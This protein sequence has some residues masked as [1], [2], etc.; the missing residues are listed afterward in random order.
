MIF[1]Y[2]LIDSNR[3][4]SMMLVTERRSINMYWLGTAILHFGTL[5]THQRS[6]GYEGCYIFEWEKRWHSEME[7]PECATLHFLTMANLP[8]SACTFGKLAL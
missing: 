1:R 6:R 3:A 7:E 5:Q 4:E 8:V 2:Q